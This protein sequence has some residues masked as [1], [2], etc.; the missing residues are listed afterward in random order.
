MLLYVDD[1]ILIGNNSSLLA[2]FTC[3]LHSEFATKDLGSFNYFL[4]LK[5]TP[6]IDG[7]FIS[8]LK[9]ARDI[10]IPAQ[11]LDSKPIHTPMVVSQH[12]SSD[13]PLFSDP[14]LYRSLVGALQ[15]L[16]IMCPDIAH[17]INFVN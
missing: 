17:A 1:I 2:R 10:L 16:T 15:C 8:Q 7:L 4:G 13:G 5:A 3:K 9:Y 6:T 12:L 14:T 11:L